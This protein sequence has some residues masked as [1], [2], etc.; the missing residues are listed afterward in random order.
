MSSYYI[1][2][3][4]C[5]MNKADSES[6]STA[7]NQAGLSAAS[8]ASQADV[9]VLN[10]CVV[11]QSAE[12]KVIGTLGMM[13]S[14]KAK[15]PGQILALMGCMVGAR[16]EELEKRFPQVDVFMRPQQFAP[17]LELLEERLGIDTEGCLSAVAPTSPSV[18]SYVPVIHGC[19][20]MCTFCIIPFRRGRQV[21]RPIED[22]THQVDLMTQRGM[23]EVTLLGQTV[24]AYGHDFEEPCDLS[25]LLHAVHSVE[26]LE[27]LRFLTSHPIFMSQDIID[28]V[29][30]LPKVCEHI[31]LPFQAGDDDVLEAMRRRYTQGQ[32][33]ELVDRIRRTVPNVA[34]S[35]D[36]IVGFPGETHEQFMETY[37]LVED[38]RF[39]KVHMAAYSPRLGT[40]ANRR[41]PD[42]VSYEEKQQRLKALESLQKEIQEK[43]NQRLMGTTEEVL[44]EGRKKG[45]WQGRTRQ[46]KLVFFEHP[47]DMLGRTV[48]VKIE[49]A[50]AWSL[51][52][53]PVRSRQPSHAEVS[54]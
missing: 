12:D 35:T 54:P 9:V 17:V 8:D 19:D 38:I 23:R 34:I 1:W 37:K 30:E 3:I 6:L 40:F 33:R 31:N 32:Y 26:G 47:T 49:A 43:K 42:S 14:V 10:S 51:R 13:K 50:T 25:R 21:S 7:L 44:V 5:Q 18:S 48:E 29:A 46:D 11:R 24:D 27:R 52:G 53:T 41:L 15:K 45:R 36:V 4:G 2:T 39:D 22:I 20:L 28:A 16:T